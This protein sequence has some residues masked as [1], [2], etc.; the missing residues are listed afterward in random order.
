MLDRKTPPSEH[1][2]APSHSP[3]ERLTDQNEERFRLIFE[4]SALGIALVGVDGRPLRC[5]AALERFLGY[6]EAELMGMS[7]P[8]FTYPD[9]ITVDWNLYSELIDGRRPHYQI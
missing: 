4:G 5:N 7:F 8:E 6:S 2:P 9:D 3:P 1:P